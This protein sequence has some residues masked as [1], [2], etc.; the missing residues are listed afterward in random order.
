MEENS[1]YSYSYVNNNSSDNPNSK[2]VTRIKKPHPVRNTIIIVTMLLLFAVLDMSIV[3]TGEDEYTLIK[4]FG[5]LKRVISTSGISF[6][7][8]FIETETKL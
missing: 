8:P 3:E 4:R 7:I 6:K 1:T 5:E 2:K